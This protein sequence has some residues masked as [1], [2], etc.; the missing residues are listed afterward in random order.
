MRVIVCGGRH[1]R[2]TP[3]DY[4]ALSAL[5]ITHLYVGGKARGADGCAYRW[6]KG[7]QTPCTV[8][9]PRWDLYGRAAGP[10]RNAAQLARL[11]AEANGE[12]IAVLAFPGGKGTA[13][14]VRKAR[15]AGVEVVD[16]AP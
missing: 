3:A 2:C 15:R 13:D 9:E 5:P 7:R 16:I 4:A 10:R 11:Q 8:T 12:A 6:A 14:M 1:Y